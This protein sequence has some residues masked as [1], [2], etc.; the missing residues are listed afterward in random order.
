[1][2]NYFTRY[3]TQIGRG[4][5]NPKGHMAN[6][7]HASR[8]FVDSTYRLSPRTKFLYYVYFDI[9][10]T[11]MQAP[12]FT[13]KHGEELG[14]LV[15]TAELPKFNFE[16]ITKN[17]YNRKKLLYKQ[18]NYDPVNI[19]FHDDTQGIV[20]A[21]WA[22]YYGTY[23]QDRH[24]P[25]QAYSALHYRPSGAGALDN[26]RYGLDR[27]KTTDLFKSISIYTM[28][29]SRF[30]GY[31]LINPRITNWSHGQM[32]Y[33]AGDTVESSMTLNY[34]AV[35]YSSGIVGRNSPKGFANLH[36][37][38]MPSPLT[39][40][41]G[42][43]SNLLGQGGVL[44]GLESVFGAIGSGAAFDSFGGFLGTAVT[45]INTYKNASTLTGAGLK[46]EAINILS[47]PAS[48]ATIGG[49]IGAVFPKAQASNDTTS[50]SQRNLVNQGT[51]VDTNTASNINQN[52]A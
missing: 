6:W 24:N 48:L 32:D 50:A 44:D 31:T 8:V 22:I 13:A 52:V 35:A 16:T 26:F 40:A 3:L 9:D 11:A 18:I 25:S 21:L 46:Q 34:E 2:A 43:V 7:Q 41:G 45:A 15:K 12:G 37:D 42:G 1:M 28:S 23:I 33:S 27:N 29:R 5:L 19:T 39:M 38:N 14:V 36:Y 10:K 17:Q 47:N 49:V 4:T 51:L 30:N 20:N